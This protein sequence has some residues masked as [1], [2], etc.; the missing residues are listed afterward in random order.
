MKQKSKLRL[1]FDAVVR[2]AFPDTA[3]V[4]AVL[5]NDLDGVQKAFAKGASANAV[6]R[7]KQRDS[8][9]SISNGALYE[10]PVITVALWNS[11]Y[12]VVAEILKH[13]PDL[14]AQQAITTVHTGKTRT[15]KTVVDEAACRVQNVD[16][17]IEQYTRNTLAA[18]HAF[19]RKKEELRAGFVA[20]DPD[21]VR[22][23]AAVKKVAALKITP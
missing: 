16:P 3:L 11:G 13:N 1:A 17:T 14:D 8:G 6:H 7:F 2:A 19:P 22:K 12:D 23:L 15:G 4:K 20:S 21:A 18:N 9:V 5:T 10:T